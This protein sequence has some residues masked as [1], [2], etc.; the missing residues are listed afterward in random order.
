MNHYVM[1]FEII[2]GNYGLLAIV[3]VRV[4]SSYKVSEH[5]DEVLSSTNSAS[6]L[7]LGRRSLAPHAIPIDFEV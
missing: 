2:K 4:I 1:S 5:T 7:S 6:S 3:L